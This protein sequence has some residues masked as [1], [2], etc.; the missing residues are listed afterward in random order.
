MIT[1]W[2]GKDTIQLFSAT[3]EKV[4]INYKLR[5]SYIC[6]NEIS[7]INNF[8]IIKDIN[9]EIILGIPFITQIKPYT[10]QLDDIHTRVLGKN[11]T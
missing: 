6:N 5:N 11:P 9:E 8:M 3:G 1:R 10:F 2:L 7:F 4:K